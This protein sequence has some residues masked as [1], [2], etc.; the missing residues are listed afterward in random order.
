MSK[1]FVI[2][3]DQH[4]LTP[5]HPGRARLLLK[6]GKAAVYRRYPF[7]LIL[8]RRVEDREP[9]PLRLKIDA[10]AVTTGLAI[11]ADDTSEVVWAAELTHRGKAIKRAMDA[12]R[13]LRR[14]RRQRKTRSRKPRF[15]NRRRHEGSLPPSLESRVHTILTW[16]ARLSRLCPLTALSQELVRFDLHAM[17]QPGIA[18]VQYQQGTLAGDEVREWMLW[19][20]NRTCAYCGAREVPLQIEHIQSR[21][22]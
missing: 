7:T 11:V 12:R 4:P 17:Q 8:K 16:V 20:W 1:V 3:T 13:A 10:G 14:S 18:G 9:T 5:V 21:A 19:K 15:Q 2:D 22:R 6:G